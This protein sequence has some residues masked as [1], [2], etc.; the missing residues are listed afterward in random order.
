LSKRTIEELNLIEDFLFQEVLGDEENGVLVAKMILG[1]IMERPVEVVT[2]HTQKAIMPGAVDKHGI[3]LDVY[4][5]E[6]QGSE[7][8]SHII[9]D[10]EVQRQD[11][12]ELPKRSRYYQAVIDS[13]YL[14]AGEAY[15]NLKR[16][17][18]III[19]PRDIF[20]YDR[21]C[22]TFENRCIEEQGLSLEDGA[23]RV[24]LNS[25]G[26]N[27]SREELSKLLRYI[28]DSRKE[29]AVN[30]TTKKLHEVVEKVKHKHEVGVRYLKAIEYEIYIREKATKEG[31]E[32][33]KKAG[34]EAGKKAGMEAGKKAGMEAGKKEGW[35]AGKREMA[36][37]M[38]KNHMSLETI[39]Q[40]AEIPLEIVEKW[41]REYLDKS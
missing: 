39:A 8:G 15:E 26:K 35:E 3:R 17:W 41:K 6:K 10:V 20:G 33:G 22:Y 38:M 21:M 1:V 36:I 29:N 9:Y 7:D 34:M 23:K 4:M 11:T 14:N 37:N 40:M 18:I 5:E 13:K 19:M 16:L 32:A 28:E 25:H 31:W 30:E 27:G 24:F 2:V 12:K